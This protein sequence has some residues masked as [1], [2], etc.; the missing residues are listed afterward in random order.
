MTLVLIAINHACIVQASDR[1]TT[2]VRGL[3]VLGEHD[4]IANKTAIYLASDGVMVISFAAH[5][6][7][8]MR[9]S[10]GLRRG[11]REAPQEL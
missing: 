11:V 6:K 2:K 8:A 4:S 7:P 9:A 10:G 3:G 1:L 5:S